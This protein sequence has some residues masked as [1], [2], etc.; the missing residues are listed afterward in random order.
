VLCSKKYFIWLFVLFFIS[1]SPILKSQGDFGSDISYDELEVF[2]FLKPFIRFLCNN[3]NFVLDEYIN[4][5]RVISS[6][7]AGLDICLYNYEEHIARRVS[8]LRDFNSQRYNEFSRALI[9][10]FLRMLGFSRL[11]RER[12]GNKLIFN[13]LLF[14]LENKLI[15][16]ISYSNFGRSLNSQ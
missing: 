5:C 8:L 4:F 3:K 11:I 7:D 13:K 1:F 16:L 14:C 6:C 15:Y 2:P 12:T 9:N 10:L